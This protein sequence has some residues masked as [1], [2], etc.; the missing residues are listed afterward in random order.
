MGQELLT[1]SVAY[2]IYQACKELYQSAD[3]ERPSYEDDLDADSKNLLFNLSFIVDNLMNL[4]E[5]GYLRHH[6]LLQIKQARYD[7]SDILDSFEPELWKE[8]IT[9]I[10]VDSA[11]VLRKFL[12]EEEDNELN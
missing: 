1:D 4:C 12:K 7:L 2:K 10:S 11:D 8:V 6:R 3:L 5:E 9:K